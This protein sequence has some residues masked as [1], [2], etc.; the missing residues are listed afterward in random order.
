MA[1]IVV[2][3]VV[4][5]VVVVVVV[6]E[7]EEEVVVVVVVAVVA[8]VVV[9]AVVTTGAVG[10]W[11]V[12]LPKREIF[13]PTG[14]ICECVRGQLGRASFGSLALFGKLVSVRPSD[15]PTVD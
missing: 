8:V 4:V 6:E 2:V 3:A 7:E 14:V 1:V 15:R 12:Y 9:V 5:V 11:G 10:V 13:L